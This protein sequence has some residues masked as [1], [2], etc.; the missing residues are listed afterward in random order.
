MQGVLCLD[1]VVIHLFFIIQ[2]FPSENQ[3]LLVRRNA[4]RILNEELQ[5]FDSGGA[6]HIYSDPLASERGH[7]NAKRAFFVEDDRDAPQLDCLG[8][9]VDQFL[10]HE[11]SQGAVQDLVLDG[12][13]LPL[14]LWLPGNQVLCGNFED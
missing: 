2:L 14:S 12:E 9:V 1:V 13:T 10:G 3:P 6:L 7:R 5:F 11:E 8:I 4:L